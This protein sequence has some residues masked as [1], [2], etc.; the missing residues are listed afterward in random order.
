M[1][2]IIPRVRS[3]IKDTMPHMTRH[4]GQF[5][6][7]RGSDLDFACPQSFGPAF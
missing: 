6:H 7:V 4:L 5:E 3:R 2:Q 1:G